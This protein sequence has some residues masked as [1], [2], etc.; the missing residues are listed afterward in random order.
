MML[1]VLK[2]FPS[3]AAMTETSLVGLSTW[4]LVL[5]FAQLIVLSRGME[6]LR[7]LSDFAGPA[8]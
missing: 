6:A 4:F 2:V 7:R 5:S 1:R 3:T 8:I